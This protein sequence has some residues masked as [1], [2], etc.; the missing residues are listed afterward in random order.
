MTSDLIEFWQRCNLAGAPFAHPDDWPVLRRDQGRHI[1]E[2]P[3]DFAAFVSGHQF[4]D[5]KDTRLHL[6]LL[7]VPYGGDVGAAEIVVLLLNPGFTFTDYYAETRVPEYSRRL[8]IRLSLCCDLGSPIRPSMRLQVR[9]LWRL[10]R[11]SFVD[12]QPGTTPANVKL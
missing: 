10:T 9:V 11:R 6:S 5:F 7:P 1:H 3:Q 12:G 2:E 8:E 4:G